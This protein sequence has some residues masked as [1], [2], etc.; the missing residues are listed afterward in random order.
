MHK[1]E[2]GLTMQT[3]TID[4]N[5][6]DLMPALD[7][8]TYAMLEANLIENGCRDAI[9]IWNGV[10][11]DGHNRYEICTKHDIPFRTVEKEFATRQNAVIWIISTQVSRRNLTPIQLSYFRGL[12]YL[13]DRIIV[14]NKSGK[15]QFSEAGGDDAHNGHHPESKSTAVRIAAQYKVSKNTVRRDAKVASAIDAIG[16]TSSEA[17]R[18]ILSGEV[19]LDKKAL[20]E[21]SKIPKDDLA[22]KATEIEEG[23]YEKKSPATDTMTDQ[24]SPDYQEIPDGKAAPASQV[25]PFELALAGIQPLKAIITRLPGYI[26]PILPKVTKKADKTLLRTELRTCIDAL[27][28]LHSQI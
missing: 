4:K 19:K 21:L 6:K 25:A 24:T 11:I 2:R 28:D 10:V 22:G 9:I 8:D 23:I 16:E 3:I 18:M 14:T 17:K 1:T 12:H 27:E 13:S 15:N 20:G 26:I 7:K 5:F